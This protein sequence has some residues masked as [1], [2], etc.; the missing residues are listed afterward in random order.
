MSGGWVDQGYRMGMRRGEGRATKAGMRG[1]RC[2]GGLGCSLWA[3]TVERNRLVGEVSLWAP[4]AMS[5][6]LLWFPKSF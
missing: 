4:A 1:Q 6:L 3:G 5:K 2:G